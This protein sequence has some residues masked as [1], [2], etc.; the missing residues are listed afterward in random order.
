MT[1]IYNRALPSFSP[2]FNTDVSL[3]VC[4]L[5]TCHMEV[6]IFHHLGL[7]SL[8][9]SDS[10]RRQREAAT[11][12]GQKKSLDIS[13]TKVSKALKISRNLQ[14]SPTRLKLNKTL[15]HP[16]LTL[17]SNLSKRVQLFTGCLILSIFF[18]ICTLILCS[19][20]YFVQGELTT[21]N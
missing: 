18:V 19:L 5:Y 20:L 14:S 21:M 10:K 2:N 12:N 11:N 7:D 8:R 17:K 16:Y 9:F 3:K 4:V 13:R 1:T 15:K 6:S